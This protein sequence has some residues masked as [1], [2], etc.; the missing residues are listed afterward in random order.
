MRVCHLRFLW[1]VYAHIH[2]RAPPAHPAHMH[3][4]LQAFRHS[5]SAST[6]TCAYL[7]SP[8]QCS[9]FRF[10]QYVPWRNGK[11]GIRSEDTAL[12]RRS[13][14]LLS[15]VSRCYRSARVGRPPQ[16]GLRLS[17]GW[18]RTLVTSLLRPPPNNSVRLVLSLSKETVR[19]VSCSATLIC[20]QAPI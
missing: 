7:Y 6:A 15:G 9:Y 8:K 11:C 10:R 2:A 12:L 19:G 20:V 1:T 3:H 14:R 16:W 5:T 17:R 18:R 13:C 4:T